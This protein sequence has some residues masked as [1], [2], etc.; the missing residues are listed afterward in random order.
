MHV[1]EWRYSSSRFNLGISAISSGDPSPPSGFNL[2][3]G[4]WGSGV[5]WTLKNYLVYCWQWSH[6]LSLCSIG[7]VLTELPGRLT[8]TNRGREY[9]ELRG[10]EV[11]GECK[12]LRHEELQN[13]YLS[14]REP[15]KMR[16]AGDTGERGDRCMR[17]L[18]ALFCG[19]CDG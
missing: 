8:F 1:G 5:F 2:W 12:K 13:L 6:D 11:S 10:Q 19:T 16:C 15:S 17:L 4:T 14:L 18:K 7:T 9:L 3:V